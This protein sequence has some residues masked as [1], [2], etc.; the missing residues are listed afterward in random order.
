MAMPLRDH[1]VLM[2]RASGYS[3][4]F[5]APLLPIL[6]LGCYGGMPPNDSASGKMYEQCEYIA[7]VLEKIGGERSTHKT[8]EMLS[9]CQCNARVLWRYERER[10]ML[11]ISSDEAQAAAK[12][13]C[14]NS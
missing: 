12:R 6:L 5:C 8:N 9:H 4:K 1:C 2:R 3:L 10:G 14:G 7:N 13:R 11:A